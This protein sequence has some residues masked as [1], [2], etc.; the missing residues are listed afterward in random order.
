MR[1]GTSS[2]FTI[3]KF[4]HGFKLSLTGL[5]N[6]IRETLMQN[7]SLLEI[8]ALDRKTITKPPDWNSPE[9]LELFNE[10]LY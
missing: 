9:Q 10:F 2:A 3:H 4:L 8:L 1:P 6:R 5:T 7:L